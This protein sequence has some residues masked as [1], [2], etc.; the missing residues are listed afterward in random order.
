MTA[1]VAVLNKHAVA[2]AADSAVTMGNTHKV[3]NSANKI[4]TLSKYHPIAVMTYNNAAFM[5]TPWDIIIKEYRRQLKDR[6]LETVKDYCDDFIEFLHSRNFFCDDKTQKSFMKSLLGEFYLLCLEDIRKEK[7]FTTID[8]I[9]ASQIEEKLKNYLVEL[10]PEGK[11]TEFKSYDYE[12]FKRYAYEDLEAYAREKNFE[13]VEL[14]CYSFFHYLTAKPFLP[15][16]TGLVFVG[17]GESEIYPSLYPIEISFGI[18]HRL[19]YRVNEKQISKISE[20]GLEATIAPFAQ[21][22]VTQ[23]IIRGINP[24]FLDIIYKVTDSSITSFSNEIT[25]ILDSNPVTKTLSTAV[26]NIDQRGIIEDI[27]KQ[28]NNE[29]FRIYSKPL[30]ETVALLDKEDMANMAE[31]FIALTSLVR[32]MQPGEET[33]GGP[34]DVA[35]ISKGDGFIWINRKHYFKPELNASFFNNY[36]K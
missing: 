11:S 24:S 25:G 13:D 22:D 8:S 19:K 10:E 5:G 2:I 20:H 17:Y 3:V 15:I 4:F 23:T 16:Y 26:K 9:S 35:V 1:I 30:I 33:V 31:S 21:T 6:S 27:T 29:M 32:R 14:L 34:V 7:G 28:I 36:F 18:D 12:D